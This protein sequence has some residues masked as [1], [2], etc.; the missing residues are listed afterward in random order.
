M[1]AKHSSCAL[2]RRVTAL[3][4][5]MMF[6]CS[7]MALPPVSAAPEKVTPAALAG[8]VSGASI[9]PMKVYGTGFEPLNGHF[10]MTVEGAKSDFDATPM[11]GTAANN[12]LFDVYYRPSGS[13]EDYDKI[14]CDLKSPSCLYDWGNGNVIYRLYLEKT[15]FT[16]LKKTSYELVVVVRNGGRDQGL[17]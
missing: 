9:L 2:L 7:G 5:T 13:S 17:Q 11:A 6:V 1:Y 4:L 16:R 12:W 3:L 10:Q 8:A 15:P 14:T